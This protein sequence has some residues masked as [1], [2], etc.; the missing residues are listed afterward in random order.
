M[1]SILSP[2]HNGNC[3]VSESEVD[4]IVVLMKVFAGKDAASKFD[5][6]AIHTL[7]MSS[8]ANNPKVT[9]ISNIADSG[10][11]TRESEREYNNEGRQM[12]EAEELEAMYRR[13]YETDDAD[14]N[15]DLSM[16]S[17]RRQTYDNPGEDVKRNI[18]REEELRRLND[19]HQSLKKDPSGHLSEKQFGQDKGLQDI[20]VSN[21]TLDRP[22]DIEKLLFSGSSYS[23]TDAE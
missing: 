11:E 13:D 22:I 4:E 16:D 6:D 15:K 20:N 10:S 14:S 23:Q 18:E 2:D 19:K 9:F 12:A 17:S 5:R 21:G 1:R 7:V 3:F 8:I